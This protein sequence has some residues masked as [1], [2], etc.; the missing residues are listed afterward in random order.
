MKYL[1]F[2]AALLVGLA[3]S[4]AVSEDQKA[5]LTK[6]GEQTTVVATTF[7]ASKLIGMDVKNIKNEKVGSINELV[8]D[9]PSGQVRYAALSVGGFLGIGNKLFAVPWKS[10]VLKHESSGPFFVLDVSK[11]K[12]RNAPGFDEKN[13]PDFGDRK[14]GTEIDK[15]YGV[16]SEKTA[17]VEPG[18][19]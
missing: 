17:S 12:L 10:M 8:V 1:S 3:A 7:K 16:D 6:D 19:N 4:T 11:E 15:Y 18:A 14:F 5:V 9:A 2:L 13:W